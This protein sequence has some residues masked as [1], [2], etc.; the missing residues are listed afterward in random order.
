MG[1]WAVPFPISIYSAWEAS[2]LWCWRTIAWTFLWTGIFPFFYPRDWEVA[3]GC[4]GGH[5]CVLSHI[6]LFE[7]LDYSQASSSVHEIFQTRILERVAI[8]SSWRSSWPRGRAHVSYGSCIGRQILYHWA[9]W[10]ALFGVGGG[11]SNSFFFL[12]IL[13]W[14][15]VLSFYI[16]F[17]GCTPST[18]IIGYQLYPHVQNTFIA[19]LTPVVCTSHFLPLYCPP[20]Q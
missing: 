4:L 14:I 9:T 15:N 5:V 3:D 2:C 10:E 11:G 16:N 20:P 6:Q 1:Y 12:V 19:Y 18:V 13:F 7:P 8:S 17:K